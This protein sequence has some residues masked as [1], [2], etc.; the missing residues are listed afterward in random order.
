[1]GMSPFISLMIVHLS[2]IQRSQMAPKD[3]FSG[4][5]EFLTNW[6]Y[7][8]CSTACSVSRVVAL[9]ARGGSWCW[10]STFRGNDLCLSISSFCDITFSY[11]P[12]L[13]GKASTGGASLSARVLYCSLY[14][15]PPQVLQQL[16]PHFTTRLWNWLLEFRHYHSGLGW[17]LSPLFLSSDHNSFVSDVVI[18]PSP[19]IGGDPE[20][21]CCGIEN[22]ANCFLIT[23]GLLLH[24]VSCALC[25]HLSSL[26]RY[27][28]P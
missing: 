7:R 19:W 20:F 21:L 1:M 12:S 4:P 13:S 23:C 8:T 18:P 16:T 27:L 6:D 15:G 17:C 3:S 25:I 26:L 22:A 5:G 24:L 10:L 14:L 9:P 28:H 11:L 2:H